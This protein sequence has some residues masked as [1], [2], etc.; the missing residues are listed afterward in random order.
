MPVMGAPLI[1]ALP[2]P[3][4]LAEDSVEIGTSGGG[5]GGSA[6]GFSHQ[7]AGGAAA[8]AAGAGPRASMALV[9][10]GQG[11]LGGSNL[12][13][14]LHQVCSLGLGWVGRWRTA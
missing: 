14:G 7:P 1:P 13:D 4:K 6:A 9:G 3:Q 2:A 8:R 12:L 10:A 5:G 11:A